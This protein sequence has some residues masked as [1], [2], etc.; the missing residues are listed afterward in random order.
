MTVLIA[1]IVVGTTGVQV[2][3]E[4]SDLPIPGYIDKLKQVV[5][6]QIIGDRTVS[7][8]NFGGPLAARPGR[9][10]ARRRGGGRVGQALRPP[11]MEPGPGGKAH[12]GG[13]GPLRGPCGGVGPSGER[14]PRRGRR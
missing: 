5:D 7:E 1:G 4:T 14:G 6:T 2:S 11:S 13:L 10:A 3:V 9:L 12:P 8:R